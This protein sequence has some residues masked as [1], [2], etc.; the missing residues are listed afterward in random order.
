MI[1]HPTIQLSRRH[2]HKLTRP[3]RRNERLNPTLERVDADAQTGGCFFAGQEDAG[4]RIYGTT[5]LAY[6][7]TS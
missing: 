6:A 2:Q 7:T 5:R 1:P 4:D 3:H